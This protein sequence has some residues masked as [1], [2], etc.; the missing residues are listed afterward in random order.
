[1]AKSYQ[2][3]SRKIKINILRLFVA[4]QEITLPIVLVAI[5]VLAWFGVAINGLFEFW[6]LL[7]TVFIKGPLVPD[8]WNLFLYLSPSLLFLLWIIFYIYPKIELIIMQRTMDRRIPPVTPHKGIILALSRP[9]KMTPQ[10][11]VQKVEE[12]SNPASLYGMWSIGQLFKGMYYHKE[13]LVGIWPLTTNESKDYRICIEK[14]VS[15]FIPEAEIFPPDSCHLLGGSELEMIERTK[16]KLS[17]I[18]LKENL[19]AIGLKSSD[20]IVDITGGTKAISIGLTFG[21]LD[22]AIDIQYVEQQRYDVIPLA[23][24]AEIILDKIGQYLLELYSRLDTAR[25]G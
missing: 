4:D 7:P 24:T 8:W 14:F 25:R 18:Y 5:G 6:K 3:K 22:S 10:E 21:A 16:S 20:I 1:M 17:E 19:N 23:I 2:K 9:T 11:I 15:K 12:A 13:F